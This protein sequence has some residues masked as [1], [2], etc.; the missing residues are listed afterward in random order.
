MAIIKS[1]FHNFL[2]LQ[3]NLSWFYIQYWLYFALIDKENFSSKKRI[4]AL[5]GT[6]LISYDNNFPENKNSFHLFN[7]NFPT[8]IKLNVK[9]NLINQWF[10]EKLASF[11][12][13][14]SS[15]SLIFSVFPS[16]Q[17]FSLTVSTTFDR[18][19]V[20]SDAESSKSFSHS[21]PLKIKYF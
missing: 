16:A 15:F 7:P 10:T 4:C 3:I 11:C 14:L 12:S 2:F 8:P 9:E 19:G 20:F 1:A 13:V 17:Y 18:V 5:I 6:N 21:S